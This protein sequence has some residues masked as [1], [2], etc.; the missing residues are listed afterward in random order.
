[1]SEE[2]ERQGEKTSPG[3][4][5]ANAG[6]GQCM[7]RVVLNAQQLESS[8]A[9]ELRTAWKS[10]AVYIDHLETLNKQLE[11]RLQKAKEVEDRIRQ[12]YAESQHREKVLVR[13]LAGKEQ[14][15]Q[16]YAG[17]EPL[18]DCVAGREPPNLNRAEK[19]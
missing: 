15:V 13:R 16:D 1:M 9:E 18:V 7:S 12:Q 5:T 8:S 11:G 17:G 2:T 4:V 6:N 14:E 3:A 19:C 10:Q